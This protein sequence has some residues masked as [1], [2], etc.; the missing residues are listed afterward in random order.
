MNS[1]AEDDEDGEDDEDEKDDE[2][3]EHDLDSDLQ[4]ANRTERGVL[5]IVN[6]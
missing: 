1:S 4:A 5:G 6:V 3:D 2:D